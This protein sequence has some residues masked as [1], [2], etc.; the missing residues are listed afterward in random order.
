MSDD[1][2]QPPY[3]QRY[4]VAWTALSIIAGL[5]LLGMFFVGT[6]LL[7][8]GKIVWSLIRWLASPLI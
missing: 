6:D 1:H 3:D 5:V 8:G 2:S 4:I 7:H